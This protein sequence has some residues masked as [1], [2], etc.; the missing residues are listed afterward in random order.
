MPEQ[1]QRPHWVRGGLATLVTLGLLGGLIWRLDG[2]VVDVIVDDVR[3]GWIALA[4]V[5][6]PVQ[7]CLAAERWRLASVA[8]DAPISRW[9][10][11]REYA[12]STLVN[13]LLPS[14]I[15]GDAARVLRQRHHGLGKAARAA[16]VDRGLGQVSLAVYAGAGLLLWPGRPPGTMLL[17]GGVFLGL[18]VAALVARETVRRAVLPHLFS[19]ALLSGLLTGSF[20]A[21]FW[22]CGMALGLTS[23]NWMWSAA[24]LMLLAMSLPL[25]WGGWGPRELSAAALFPAFGM[26]P[27]AGVV[28]AALYGLSVLLGAL[29]AVI[30]PLLPPSPQPEPAP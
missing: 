25:S 7:V 28:I 5:L 2:R 8:L 23:T 27:E 10:A 18:I 13:Q 24:P 4:A 29:P 6:G 3:W 11:I 17:A 26:S 22:C 12:L 19:H 9:G 21:G 14:G 15:A 20:L 1:A 30:L 16:V